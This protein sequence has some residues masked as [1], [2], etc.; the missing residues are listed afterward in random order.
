[1]G[2]SALLPPPPPPTS[3]KDPPN[4]GVTVKKVGII[5]YVQNFRP[6]HLFVKRSGT[7]PRSCNDA[8]QRE[9]PKSNKFIEQ[10][11]GCPDD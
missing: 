6:V 4:R 1:M 10:K 2:V 3:H 9:R 11:T 5:S 8:G 7:F